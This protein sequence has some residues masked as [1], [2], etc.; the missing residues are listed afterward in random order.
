[1]DLTNFKIGFYEILSETVTPIKQLINID[2]EP[3]TKVVVHY[4]EQM[5]T[6]KSE[7]KF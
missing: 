1:M 6:G 3:N 5:L 4:G 2:M 7:Y